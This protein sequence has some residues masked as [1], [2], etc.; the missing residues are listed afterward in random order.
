MNFPAQ[1]DSRLGG[2]S[3]YWYGAFGMSTLLHLAA[4]IVCSLIVVGA[5]RVA[6]IHSIETRLEPLTEESSMRVDL[7]EPVQLS[8]PNNLPDRIESYAALAAFGPGTPGPGPYVPGEV[9]APVVPEIAAPSGAPWRIDDLAKEVGGPIGPGGGGGNGTGNGGGGDG[10]SAEFF[11]PPVMGK[12]FVYVVDSSQSM[13]HPHESEARTRLG[14]VKIE[15]VRSVAS[16][17]P[18]MQFFIIYFNQHARPMPAD[19]LVPATQEAGRYLEWAARVQAEGQTDPTEALLLALRLRPDVIYFLT[20]GQ[21]EP[22]IV[23]RVTQINAGRVTIHTYCIGD[24]GGEPL[25]KAVA[26]ANNG[27]YVFIP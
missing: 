17:D 1:N 16:M 11:G 26:Q 22:A 10:K 13:N 6:P 9:P 7:T 23:K 12:R 2:P 20:D 24:A 19:N 18:S 27:R 4:T 3:G 8:E 25:L 5:E 15:L 21:F 14:R